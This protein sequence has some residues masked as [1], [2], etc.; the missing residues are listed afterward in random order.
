MKYIIP[1]LC[2]ALSACA[3]TRVAE[4]GKTV[5]I[6]QANATEVEFR[7]ANGSYLHMRGVNH[8]TPTRAGGSVVGTAFSGAAALGTAVMTR[9]LIH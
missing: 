9:G 5:F 4:G 7:S 2:A 6:T 8:S 1:L 3:Y